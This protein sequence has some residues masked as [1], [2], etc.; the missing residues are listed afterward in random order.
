M[1]LVFKSTFHVY[2]FKTVLKLP[3]YFERFLELRE[4]FFKG[5]CFY[6]D[7]DIRFPKLMEYILIRMN[8]L[9]CCC[10]E[11]VNKHCF[12]FSYWAISISLMA[13]PR[14]N[15]HLF[16]ESLC[17]NKG[18]LQILCSLCLKI[19]HVHTVICMVVISFFDIFY[20]NFTS[21]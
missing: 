19:Y 10:W 21:R 11:Y 7:T 2:Y 15:F 4:C 8:F 14:W 17:F 20:S 16:P 5:D 13:A 1:K 6:I 9:N 18:F 12:G 3:S